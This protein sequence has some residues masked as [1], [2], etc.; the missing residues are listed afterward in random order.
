MRQTRA[1]KP[2]MSPAPKNQVEHPKDTKMTDNIK[3]T[4][5]HMHVGKKISGAV[6]ALVIFVAL[7]LPLL[8]VFYDYEPDK[9]IVIVFFLGGLVL[10]GVPIQE[11]AKAWRSK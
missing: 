3:Q 8:Q 9:T 7:G 11:L 2:T 6:G 1:N 5:K 10:L 4:A